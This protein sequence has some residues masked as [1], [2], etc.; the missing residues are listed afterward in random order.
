MPIKNAYKIPYK[1]W[2][3]QIFALASKLPTETQRPYSESRGPLTESELE[4]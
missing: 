4:N 3:R 2:Q 1:K